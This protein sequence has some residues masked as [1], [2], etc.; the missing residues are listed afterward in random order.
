MKACAPGPD[1]EVGLYDLLARVT[2]D[3]ALSPIASDRERGWLLLPDGGPPLDQRFQGDA[4]TVLAALARVL[5]RYA[6]MQRTLASHA[7]AIVALGVPDMRPA[8]MPVRFPEAV[9]VSRPYVERAGTMDAREQLDRIEALEGEFAERCAR[10]AA[11]PVPAS[12]D[13]NDLHPG[14]I[15]PGPDNHLDRVRFYDWGD[16]VVS[17]PFAS[18][19]VVLQVAALAYR[20]RPDDPRAVRIRDAYLEVF[21]DLAPLVELVDILEDACR[22]ATVARALIWARA[23]GATAHSGQET[24]PASDAFETLRMLLGPHP[25]RVEIS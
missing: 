24:V 7:D 22:V 10:L 21:T 25:Y 23:T 13:Y 19:L 18:L 6:D 12:L 17:H 3:A 20:A 11:S 2:P 14:N 15:L 4:D 1:A 9:A 8:T 5:P 16:S